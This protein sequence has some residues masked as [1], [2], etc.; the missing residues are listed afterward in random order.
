MNDEIEYVHDVPTT[1][2]DG[3]LA[4]MAMRLHYDFTI[5][6]QQDQQTVLAYMRQIHSEIVGKGFYKPEHEDKFSKAIK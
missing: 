6:T 4:A 1:P 3:L 2:T 5:M